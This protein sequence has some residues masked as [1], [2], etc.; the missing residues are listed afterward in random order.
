MSGEDQGTTPSS[1][2]PRRRPMQAERPPGMEDPPTHPSLPGG[3]RGEEADAART[4]HL[5]AGPAAALAVREA[6]E[7]GAQR[8]RRETKRLEEEN[9]ILRE[10]AALFTG[11][12]A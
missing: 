11:R 12:I 7:E 5:V 8:L 3:R 9:T 6:E 1:R 4:R 10:A 2:D